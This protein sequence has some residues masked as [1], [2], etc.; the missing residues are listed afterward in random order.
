MSD[1]RFTKRL[2]TYA[3]AMFSRVSDGLAS[4]YLHTSTIDPMVGFRFK[5][6]SRER[7][8]TSFRIEYAA[9]DR[10]TRYL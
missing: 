6:S 4:G 10:A 7:Q 9:A 1:Y 3:G 5:F 8:A 2:D